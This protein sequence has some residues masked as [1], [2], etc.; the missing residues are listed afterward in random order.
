MSHSLEKPSPNPFMAVA[1]G[2]GQPLKGL[3]VASPDHQVGAHCEALDEGGV[4]MA[5]SK[6]IGYF[7]LFQVALKYG[8]G[9]LSFKNVKTQE[10]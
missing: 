1:S 3:G 4:L 2:E 7:W 6:S 5:P 10:T 9:K 8:V